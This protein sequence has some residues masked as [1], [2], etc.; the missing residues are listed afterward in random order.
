VGQE[1]AKRYGLSLVLVD[2]I[3]MAIQAVTTPQEH[4]ALHAFVAEGSRAANSAESVYEGLIAVAEAV[5][6]ALLMVMAHHMVV[7]GAGAVIVEGD[8][9][10]PRLATPEYIGS[11]PEFLGVNI[12]GVVKGVFLC[13]DEREVIFG[14]I[15]ARRRGFEKKSVEEQRALCEGSWKYS[16]Y[17]VGQAKRIGVPVLLSRPYGTLGERIE[18]AVAGG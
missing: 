6:P 8:G 14:N 13:E 17:L 9:M 15:V 2:D 7:E 3:R 12:E 18:T 16:R 4:P 1:L 10:L 5:E 11:Q